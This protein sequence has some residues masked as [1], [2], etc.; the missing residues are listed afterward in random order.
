[1]LGVITEYSPLFNLPNASSDKLEDN[2][3]KLGLLFLSFS[4]TRNVTKIFWGPK[5]KE[6]DYLSVLNGVRVICLLYVMFG[7]GY[8]SIL[9]SPVSE[10]IGIERLMTPWMFSIVPGGFFAVDV[11]F[12]LSAFLG[13]YLML[14]KFFK[15]RM[16][17]GLIYFH[18][19]YRLVIPIGL[20]I[21]LLLTVYVY[22]GNGP[23]WY[24]V[25]DKWIDG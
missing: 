19:I 24:F 4:F 10:I 17:F 23:V 25:T 15:R 12:F 21:A 18:R 14:V 2:K 20:V 11:F 6:D 3:T 13:A 1:M 16:N 8:S 22:L 9:E 5:Q 7:H